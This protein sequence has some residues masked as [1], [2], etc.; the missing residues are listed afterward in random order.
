MPVRVSACPQWDPVSADG[1][2]NN[3]WRPSLCRV[4][5]RLVWELGLKVGRWR[6]DPAFMTLNQAPSGFGGAFFG[7]RYSWGF[8]GTGGPYWWG[9]GGLS[10]FLGGLWGCWV[11]GSY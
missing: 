1:T 4:P 7:S 6:T 8:S 11:A 9:G 2:R 3:A 5:G 10:R